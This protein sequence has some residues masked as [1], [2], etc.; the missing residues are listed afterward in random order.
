MQNYKC[1]SENVFD[2]RENVIDWVLLDDL[3]PV[4]DLSPITRVT[5]KVGETLIDSDTAIPAGDVIWWTDEQDI[6]WNGEMV[7]TDVLKMKL[8]GQGL[9]PGIYNGC[10]LDVYEPTAPAG[11]TWITDASIVVHSS[12]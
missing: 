7:T 6:L 3:E 10:V 1:V 11:V 2:G 12:G 9:A 5:I 8:G 4:I